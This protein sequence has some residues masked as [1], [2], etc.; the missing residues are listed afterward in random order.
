[1]N[2]TIRQA[3]VSDASKI[4]Q[5]ERALA[6]EPGIS[7]PRD[8]DEIQPVQVYAR[9][10]CRYQEC[11]NSLYLVAESNL[12]TKHVSVSDL[13]GTLTLSG[14]STK[15]TRH[16]AQLAIAVQQE[17]R[18]RTVGRAL[19]HEAVTWVHGQ[20]SIT[21]V[22]LFVYTDNTAAIELYKRFGFSIEGKCNRGIYVNGGYVDYYVMALLI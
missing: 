2:I 8:L 4:W 10:I 14:G 17:Y 22:A 18:G 20:R 5:F 15:A 11:S 21:R 7:F 6:Q 13:V 9:E 16:V 3:V 1:M 19:M 12:I